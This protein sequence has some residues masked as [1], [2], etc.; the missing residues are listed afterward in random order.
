M[1]PTAEPDIARGLIMKS[2]PVDGEPV[3]YVVYVPPVYEPGKPCPTI[4]FLNGRG[5][6][7]MAEKLV[8]TP[9]SAFH[10]EKDEAV[11]VERSREMERSILPRRAARAS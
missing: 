3:K 8:G 4:V 6:R 10:G 1:N 5:D 2:A 9:V 11:P 7:E